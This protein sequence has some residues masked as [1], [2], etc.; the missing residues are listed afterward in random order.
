M[1]DPID[2]K[3][4]LI[5]AHLLPATQLPNFMIWLESLH[6]NEEQCLYLITRW[7]TYFK[8]RRHPNQ[9]E[10]NLNGKASDVPQTQP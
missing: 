6:L 7:R 2:P 9:I 3:T 1:P 8:R 4:V 5:P 10:M